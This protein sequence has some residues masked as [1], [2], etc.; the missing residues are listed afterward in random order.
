[1]T[2]KRLVALHW[3]CAHLVDADQSFPNMLVKGKS[4]SNLV[5]LYSEEPEWSKVDVLIET[6]PLFQRLNPN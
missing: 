3:K 5:E 1:M 2:A 6:I 4:T